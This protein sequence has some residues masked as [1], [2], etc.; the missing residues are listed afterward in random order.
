[1]S[2]EFDLFLKTFP[3][4]GKAYLGLFKSVMDA[5]AL[6]KKTKQLILVAVMASQNYIPGVRAHVP[7]ALAAGATRAEL[8]EAVLTILPVAGVNGVLEALPVVF[9]GE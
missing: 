8:A 9:E 1:M 5:P 2:K 7:Q 4:A 6:D 3:E